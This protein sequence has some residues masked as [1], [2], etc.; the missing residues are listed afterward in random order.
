MRRNLWEADQKTVAKPSLRHKNHQHRG[1][2]LLTKASYQPSGD[3]LA[4]Y[5][6]ALGQVVSP[7]PRP[8]LPLCDFVT[9]HFHQD[10]ASLADPISTP[11]ASRPQSPDVRSTQASSG[12]DPPPQATGES[13]SLPSTRG[14]QTSQAGRPREQQPGTAPVLT[15]LRPPYPGPRR[16]H[17][18][19]RSHGRCPPRLSSGPSVKAVEADSKLSAPSMHRPPVR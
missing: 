4:V 7:V 17:P 11:T 3:Q 9:P 5:R 16:E 2:S 6:A 10:T 13:R 15:S 12:A 19:T 8:A 18:T 14:Q 1:L